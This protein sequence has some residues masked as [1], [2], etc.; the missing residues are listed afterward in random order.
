MRRDVVPGFQP[1][2]F[3]SCVTSSADRFTN[4]SPYNPRELRGCVAAVRSDYSASS[5]LRTRS[6]S[7]QH[8]RLAE[9]FASFPTLNG[10]SNPDSARSSIVWGSKPHLHNL[11]PL[12][13]PL[14][15]CA[16]V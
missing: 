2:H 8:A 5:S 10:L 4:L 13:C 16:S 12:L 3:H 1:E 15:A 6:Y 7:N 11:H 9:D 14:A